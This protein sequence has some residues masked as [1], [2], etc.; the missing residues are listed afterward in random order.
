MIVAF[1]QR[2]PLQ[3]SELGLEQPCSAVALALGRPVF[4]GDFY[5]RL[6][7][8]SWDSN[9]PQTDTATGAV[10]SVPHRA[11]VK[12]KATMQEF[13]LFVLMHFE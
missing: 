7:G 2:F 10:W 4:M 5:G 13:F 9:W 6:I 1:S 8:L 12:K 11:W 3:Q